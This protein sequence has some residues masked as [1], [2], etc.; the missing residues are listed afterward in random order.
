MHD[1][2][3]THKEIQLLLNTHTYEENAVITQCQDSNIS[4]AYYINTAITLEDSS[5]MSG[6]RC[7]CVP[8]P[9]RNFEL[10]RYPL[11]KC[12]IGDHDPLLI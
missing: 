7:T 8:V 3:V 12:T 1:S 11:L 9:S 4:P 6:V 2:R 5:G 10:R